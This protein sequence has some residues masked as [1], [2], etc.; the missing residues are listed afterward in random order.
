MT[1]SLLEGLSARSLTSATTM[2]CAAARLA[3]APRSTDC[4]RRARLPTPWF[5]WNA[6]A[7]A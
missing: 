1:D 2:P 6:A 4:H 7:P 5:P 3:T